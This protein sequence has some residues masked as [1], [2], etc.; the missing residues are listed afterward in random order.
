MLVREILIDLLLLDQSRLGVL[1]V[2]CKRDGNAGLQSSKAFCRKQICL[3]L[4][5]HVRGG[6]VPKKSRRM[7]LS[8]K[9]VR[10]F[11]KF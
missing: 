9:S 10:F 6:K 3:P 1:W 4:C 11:L 7:K 5:L 2:L 8:V